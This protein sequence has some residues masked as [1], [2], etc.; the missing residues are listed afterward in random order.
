MR[1]CL[2]VG[3]ALAGV[4]GLLTGCGMGTASSGPAAGPA[5]TGT[6]HGGQQPVGSSQVYLY[7]AG[8]TGYG[9]GA[10]SLLNGPGYVTTDPV[11][12]S[13]SI[14]GDYSCTSESSLV[15]LVAVGGN[16][17]L[18][19]ASTNNA[20][21]AEM[22]AL[23]PC[24]Y[25]NGTNY[26]VNP[27][28]DVVINEVTTVASVYAL[29]QFMTPGT[30]EVGTSSTNV[31]GLTNAFA[32]VNN[33]VDIA[34]GTAR[35][36][37]PAGNGT[38]PQQE[39]NT[40]AD[41]LATCVNSAGGT[42]NCSTLIADATPSGGT[43]PSDTIGVALSIA[44]NPSN[45]VGTLNSLV[46]STA[47]FQ[48]NTVECSCGNPGTAPLDWTMSVVYTFSGQPQGPIA[49]DANGD[50]WMCPMNGGATT[51][52]ATELSPTGVLLSGSGFTVGGY[53]CSGITID[54]TGNVWMLRTY[55]YPYNSLFGL[56]SSGQV[57]SPSP[58]GYIFGSD[59]NNGFNLA[60]D[61]SGDIWVAGLNYGLTKYSPANS[62]FTNFPVQTGYQGYYNVVLDTQ[63]NIWSGCSGTSAP[64]CEITSSGVN[65]VSPSNF[66]NDEVGLAVDHSGAVWA[67]YATALNDSG[68]HQLIKISGGQISYFTGGGLSQADNAGAG[69]DPIAIDGAGHVWVADSLVSGFLSE[70]DNQG[71]A[72]SPSTTAMIQ[73]NGYGVP[74][75]EIDASGSIWISN[76]ASYDTLY[77]VIG[78]AAPVTTPKALAL[79]NNALGVR[80]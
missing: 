74:G 71:D 32:N 47:P 27:A 56:N 39:I 46:T 62:Q 12:G 10:Q 3:V 38:V 68:S 72:I 35:A 73:A 26:T 2:W 30:Y 17:G 54:L 28:T 63:G 78:V 7:E 70:F 58:N 43:M 75:F 59:L 19:P 45:A 33:L 80:P 29:A 8:T 65:P 31:T 42:G 25:W 9:T 1:V 77:Q 48:P 34:S 79:K 53:G 20:N 60:S 67:A 44:L 66:P 5:I 13:F 6:V 24:S 4:T 16:P 40:L 15:Y 23:G 57:I 64:I 22:A 21:L 52:T 69:G 11:T 50:V 14:S 37:T 36:K 49:V 55:T 41:I 51:T 61:A 18:M 76:D